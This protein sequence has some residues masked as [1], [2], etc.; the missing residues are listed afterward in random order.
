MPPSATTT[1]IGASVP[2]VAT[3]MALMVCR[4]F[5]AWSKTIECSDSKTSSVTSSPSMPYSWKISSP[6]SVS[7]LWNAG[8]QCMNLTSGLPVA[9][10]TSLF[11]WYGVSSL[12]RSSQ[13]LLSSPIETQTSV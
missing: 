10:S 2:S 5:S 4:R 6:T 13:T 11:T 12:I 3:M 7:R 9:A 1:R 8:R